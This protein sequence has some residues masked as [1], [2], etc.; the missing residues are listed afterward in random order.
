MPAYRLIDTFA[1]DRNLASM[2]G[3]G[4]D[5]ELCAFRIIRLCIRAGLINADKMPKWWLDHVCMYPIESQHSTQN[6][7][8]IFYFGLRKKVAL[9]RLCYAKPHPTIDHENVGFL[10]EEE[11]MPPLSDMSRLLHRIDRRSARTWAL[12]CSTLLSIFGHAK[13]EIEPDESFSMSSATFE[14]LIIFL[15]L[16]HTQSNI[17]IGSSC[18]Y[19]PCF[20]RWACYNVHCR[21]KRKLLAAYKHAYIHHIRVE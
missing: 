1:V 8:P 9:I 13:F 2:K 15:Y 3:S 5:M 18:Y 19:Y 11:I 17:T 16:L 12:K 14:A 4:V 21:T 10:I 7:E 6:T 20:D